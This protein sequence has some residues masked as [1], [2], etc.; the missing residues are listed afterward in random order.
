LTRPALPGA[1]HRLV[2]YT[3]AGH[4]V[5]GAGH[6]A[7]G[8]WLWLAA[9]RRIDARPTAHFAQEIDGQVLAVRA[10]FANDGRPWVTMDQAAPR[11]AAGVDDAALLATALGLAED[12]LAPGVRPQVVSTGAGHL[13]VRVRDQST[14]DRALPDPQRLRQVLRSAG[15]EGC[16]LHA[17][18]GPDGAVAY[19]RFFNPTVGI[20]EDPGTG[21]AA[22]PL[23]ALLARQGVITDGDHSIVQ[24]QSMG[25]PSRILITL[26]GS[27]VRISATGVVVADGLLHL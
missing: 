23:V 24:G 17:L 18:G 8:A 4:E 11:F 27:T 21:T 16:Y 3:A 7:L 13:M 25:R 22:G 20:V 1:Q 26:A 12:D 10:Q 6:N 14:V 5:G 9:A 15:G 2:S 19:A